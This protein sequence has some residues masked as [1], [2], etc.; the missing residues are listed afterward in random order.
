[1]NWISQTVAAHG[2]QENR[3]FARLRH[4]RRGL[5]IVRGDDSFQNRSSS[6]PDPLRWAPFLFFRRE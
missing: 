2:C 3:R 5:R 6:K 1:M 4:R